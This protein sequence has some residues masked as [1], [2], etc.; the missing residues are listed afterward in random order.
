MGGVS[1][2]GVAVRFV[3]WQGEWCGSRMPLETDR[4]WRTTMANASLENQK[5]ILARQDKIMSN[6]RQILANQVKLGKVLANQREIVRNQ[7]KILA[8]QA[9]ILAN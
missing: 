4:A 8:N 6:Q 1:V 2:T 7:K 3:D 9:A 5:K